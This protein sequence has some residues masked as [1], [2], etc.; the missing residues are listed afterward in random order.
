MELCLYNAVL[1]A[2]SYDGTKFTY[3]NQLASSHQVPSKREEWFD[4]ACCPPN[5]LRLLGQIGGYVWTHI[6]HADGSA[7]INVHLFVS[8]TLNFEAG[9]ESVTL[10]QQSDWPWSGNIKFRMKSSSKRVSMKV[11]IPGW[12][13]TWSVNIPAVTDFVVPYPNSNSDITCTRRRKAR[14]RLPDPAC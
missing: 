8:S 2:M 11:R 13:E 1:T 4:C 14:E 7:Q 9:E 3:V 10:E 12:A 5:V 6:A